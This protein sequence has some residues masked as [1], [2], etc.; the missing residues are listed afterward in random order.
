MPFAFVGAFG[1]VDTE[2]RLLIVSSAGAGQEVRGADMRQARRLCYPEARSLVFT[3]LIFTCAATAPDAR[4]EIVKTTGKADWLIEAPT[5]ARL[6][7]AGSIPGAMLMRCWDEAQNITLASDL[8]V[9]AVDPGLY[10][11]PSALGSHIISAG[12]SIS[13]HGVLLKPPGPRAGASATITFASEILGV[14]VTGR[15]SARRDSGRI[16]QSDFLGDGAAFDAGLLNRGLELGSDF[17]RIAPDQLSIQFTLNA[18]NPGDFARIITRSSTPSGSDDFVFGGSS[19]MILWDW[20]PSR[21]SPSES[22]PAPG[23]ACLAGLC[24]LHA[25]RRNRPKDAT[26][27]ASR[28]GS[29]RGPR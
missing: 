5:D 26:S 29:R 2:A 18:S 4:A 27:S 7:G 25:L 1:M 8:R 17:F 9:D 3:L 14:I 16:E 23:A 12:T 15:T 11:R 19:G 22:T 6:R 24:A 28:G 20:A 21:E 13:S 10:D